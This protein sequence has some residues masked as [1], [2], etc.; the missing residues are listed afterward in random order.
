MDQ[1][2][3][4][5]KVIHTYQGDVENALREDNVSKAK[6]FVAE[7]KKEGVGS[8]N[9]TTSF[10]L[11]AVGVG[12]FFILIGGGLVY[13]FINPK[14]EVP[15]GTQVLAPN[16]KED[17]IL[18]YDSYTKLIF[19]QGDKDKLERIIQNEKQNS[20]SM[21]VRI[22]SFDTDAD[23]FMYLLDPEI[24]GIFLRAL[25]PQFAFG[26]ATDENSISNPFLILKIESYD[27]AK[28]G[29]LSEEGA[30]IKE[31]T[32]IL[33]IP[34]TGVKIRDILIDGKDARALIDNEDRIIFIYSFLNQN[35][36]V[37]TSDNDT[38]R[39]IKERVRSVN[40]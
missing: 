25:K 31:L 14:K 24:S 27:S 26:L 3:G 32:S 17:D 18:V 2:K 4:D 36:L 8:P 16:N 21:G 11:R 15:P 23:Q 7:Q 22:L 10:N 33:D 19:P 40:P 9:E 37:I 12:I 38:F 6:V 29:L 5:L 20:P 30:L 34:P 28:G 39:T 13:Y 1:E 35:T